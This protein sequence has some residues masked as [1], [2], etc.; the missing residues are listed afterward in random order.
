M[1]A[2]IYV[3]KGERNRGGGELRTDSHGGNWVR[4]YEEESKEGDGSGE[5]GR[6]EQVRGEGE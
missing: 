6:V 1:N 4:L 3:R 5:W 2:R